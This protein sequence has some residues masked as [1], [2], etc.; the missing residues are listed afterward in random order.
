[1]FMNIY[2]F[3][4]I[5]KF[6]YLFI[7]MYIIYIY[8]Y[9]YIYIYIYI[10]MVKGSWKLQFSSTFILVYSIFG[11]VSLLVHKGIINSNHDWQIL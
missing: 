9:I 3:V 1:M 8:L 6:I 5:Y 7:Y 2:I 10:L 4:Y 11:L